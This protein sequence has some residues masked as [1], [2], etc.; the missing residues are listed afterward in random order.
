MKLFKILP[1][2]KSYSAHLGSIGLGS[3]KGCAD[4]ESIAQIVKRAQM[5]GLQISFGQVQQLVF[6]FEVEKISY[7]DAQNLASRY[8]L[9]LP[10]K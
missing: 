9:M 2:V 3:V 10:K 4:T 5:Y 8:N 6:D 1:G 7:A